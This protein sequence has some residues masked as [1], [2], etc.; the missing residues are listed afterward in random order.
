[1][2]LVFAYPAIMVLHPLVVNWIAFLRPYGIG[3]NGRKMDCTGLT[4][5]RRIVDQYE[6]P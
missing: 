6:P 2:A 4:A 3:W 1:M 5:E